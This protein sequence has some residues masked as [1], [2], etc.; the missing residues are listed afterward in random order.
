[1]P[2]QAEQQ[3]EQDYVRLYEEFWKE[4]VENA[5]GTLNKDQVMRELFDYKTVMGHCSEI[6]LW[7]S[8]DATGKV[9]VEPQVIIGLHNQAYV[10]EPA[11][12][13]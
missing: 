12:D 7:A 9:L 8:H 3:D 1:M 11:H 6:Y 5:D 13:V 10:C 2:E 4:L